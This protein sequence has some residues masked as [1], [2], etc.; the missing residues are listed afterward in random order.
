MHPE[1]LS[2]LMHQTLGSNDSE[3]DQPP[4]SMDH[5]EGSIDGE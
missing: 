1:E 4:Q 3:N 2:S 5:P